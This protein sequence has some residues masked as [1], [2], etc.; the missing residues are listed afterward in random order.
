[1]VTHHH[2]IFSVNL[3]AYVRIILCYKRTGYR[4]RMMSFIHLTYTRIILSFLYVSTW[5]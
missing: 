1:M 3:Y 4:T 2:D 5:V